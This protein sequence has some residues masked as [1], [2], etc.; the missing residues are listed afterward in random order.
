[1]SELKELNRGWHNSESYTPQQQQKCSIL[2]TKNEC[3]DWKLNLDLMFLIA[4]LLTTFSHPKADELKTAPNHQ[5]IRVALRFRLW[6]TVRN[7]N[8][9]SV[10]G[11]L[12]QIRPKSVRFSWRDNGWSTLIAVHLMDLNLCKTMKMFYWSTYYL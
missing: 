3:L 10:T 6:E 5:F 4:R 1:M 11:R 9:Y 8:I 12:V 2:N 7:L